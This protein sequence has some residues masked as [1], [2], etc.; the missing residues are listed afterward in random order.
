MLRIIFYTIIIVL[1]L[2]F[3]G[4]SLQNIIHS[5][6]GTANFGYIGE[7]VLSGFRFVVNFIGGII[8][9]FQGVIHGGFS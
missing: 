9:W 1:F 3:F 8:M 7:L 5:P 6:T 2:S 4:I